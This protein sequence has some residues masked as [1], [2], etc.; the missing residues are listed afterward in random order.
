MATTSGRLLA[1]RV[2][3]CSLSCGPGRSQGHA[4]L[5]G[6]QARGSKPAGVPP[7]VS[8][9]ALSRAM[10]GRQPMDLR[11]TVGRSPCSV[12]T[13]STPT[14]CRV[15]QLSRSGV[16]RCARREVD[17]GRRV[18]GKSGASG[19]PDGIRDDQFGGL[20]GKRAALARTRPARPL[21]TGD[22]GGLNLGSSVDDYARAAAAL[23]AAPEG[24]VAVEVNVSCPNLEDRPMFACCRTATAEVIEASTVVG[25]RCGPSSVRT[26]TFLRSPR[27]PTALCRGGVDNTLLGM[28]ID[29]EQRRPV[30]G[31]KR[32][33]LS[34][35][36]MH[37]VAIRAVYDVH[38]ALPSLPIVGVGGTSSGMDVVEFLLAGASAVEVGTAT[39]ADPRAPRR[40]LA[41]FEHWCQ[42]H[43]V[44]SVAELIGGAHD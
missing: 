1:G 18:G 23:A 40:I 21:A 31:A 13:A 28:V 30:L 15:R 33:G 26:P 9:S 37:P 14:W 22:R 7:G 4:G 2:C 35:A 6:P 44:E 8:L 11:T 43:G 32:G 5:E 36:A 38:E 16:A 24:V 3:H 39:F 41:E 20:Q 17:E 10:V 34:G 27:P 25:R 12:M 19:A 29:V 42:R